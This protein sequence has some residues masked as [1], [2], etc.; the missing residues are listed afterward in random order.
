[1]LTQR[2]LLYGL[3]ALAWLCAAPALWAQCSRPLNVP[4]AALGLSVTTVGDNVGGLYPELLRGLAGKD[5]CS[6]VFSIVPRARQEVMFET[7]RADLLVP[8]TR[9]KRRDEHG[10]FV[11]MISSR[12]QLISL[13][14]ERPT[15][16][17]LAELQERRDLR[18]VV[19][20]G[21]DYGDSYQAL[22]KVLGQQGRLLQA[23][24]PI[25]VARMLNS[26]MADLTI[27]SATIMTGALQGDARVSFLLDR[28]RYEPVEELPWGE[29]G[30]YI[31]GKP[32]LAEAD[33]A[34]L[35]ELLERSAKSGVLWRAF[36]RYYP[37][38]GL[39][40]SIKPR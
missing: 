37:P 39:A 8:A 10:I 29:S 6:M 20:R 32:V 34:L 23:V 33:R 25:S 38:G 13:Q 4:V 40:G 3:A 2:N 12:A 18:V 22:L 21:Y 15:L 11:P 7:G 1:M 24:D 9:T 35:R 16:H 14:S 19:V 31:S 27:M 36:Q 17:S 5:G 30:I 26:G 28:L